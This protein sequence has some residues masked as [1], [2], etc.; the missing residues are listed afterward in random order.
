MINLS[1][2]KILVTGADGFVGRHLVE[3]LLQKRGVP[4]ENVFLPA[5]RELDLTKW[6]DCR[7]AVAGQEVVIH[8]AAKVG[9][10]G[11]NL[12]K[13]GEL[14]Y[15]NLMMG[16]QLME[17]A[18]QA[19]VQKFVGVA[20]V[21]AYPK[22]APVPFKEDDMWNGYPEE[23]NAPYGLAKKMMLVQAQ[24]YRKQ[25][26]FNAVTLFPVNMYGPGDSFDPQKS[27]VIAAL[28]KKV[29]DAKKEGR[30][31]IDVW[32]TGSASREFLY[33]P[34]GAEGILLAAEQYDKP[35]AVNIGSG[36]EITIKELVGL[37]AQL[38]DFKGEIRWDASKP[39][40]QPRRMLDVSRAQKEFG[41]TAT[42][43]FME[44]LKNTIAWYH[45]NHGK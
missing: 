24:A 21:C 10:I 16:T 14:F 13:P 41:F 25:Y 11:F 6:E 4:K 36:K 33:A 7:K 1:Q 22:F 44:G 23:T 43:D 3:N 18:R 17:A 20:T 15:E 8:L 40:G 30:A 31:F 27:H 38:M 2:K 19:G 42:T 34:D 26:G 28:I 32:G 29:D 9:G 35:E 5:A 45:K 12:E 37:I 39:D